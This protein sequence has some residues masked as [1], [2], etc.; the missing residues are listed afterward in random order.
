[1]A[2]RYNVL[3]PGVDTVN[4]AKIEGD[5]MA[6]ARTSLTSVG[7]FAYLRAREYAP[8]RDIFK[9]SRSRLDRNPYYS[10]GQ[11]R[12]GQFRVEGVARGVAKSGTG[13]WSFKQRTYS[14]ERTQQEFLRQFHRQRPKNR[15]F[16]AI[17]KTNERRVRGHERS[18]NP[19]FGRGADAEYIPG[20]RRI[21]EGGKILTERVGDPEYGLGGI[22]PPTRTSYAPNRGPKSVNIADRL[23]RRGRREVQRLAQAA[24]Q[25]RSEGRSLR[26]VLESPGKNGRRQTFA[27]RY[28]QRQDEVSIV[29]GGR[30][31]DSITLDDIVETD[32]ELSI[33]I[34]TDPDEQDYAQYQEYGTSRHPAQP[35]MRPALYEARPKLRAEFRKALLKGRT[36]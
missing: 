34:Y 22:R 20:A 35:F 15:Q 3:R 9:R 1:M 24:S 27:A 4:W 13:R 32:T 7:T 8:V 5:I 2:A 33:E 29:L 17:T 19:V 12:R 16:M 25:A 6:A 18:M 21:T 14:S 31:R 36:A 23:N 28:S 11:N 10:G 30:L 26:D